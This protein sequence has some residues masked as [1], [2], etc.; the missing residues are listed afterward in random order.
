STMAG[1]FRPWQ[2]CERAALNSAKS[3]SPPAC[4]SGSHISLFLFLFWELYGISVAKTT[5]AVFKG[6]PHEKARFEAGFLLSV[7]G[8]FFLF[9][10]RIAEDIAAAPDGFDV[11]VAAGGVR[12]FLAQLAD[13]HVDDL[14]FRF[15]HAAVKVIQEHFLGQGRALAQG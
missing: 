14:H 5:R 9:R 2:A 12:Q 3:I 15:V 6:L 1:L 8:R 7:R 13:E 10:F 11:V 4:K